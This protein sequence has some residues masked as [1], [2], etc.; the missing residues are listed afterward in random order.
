MHHKTLFSRRLLIVTGKG[1]VGKTTIA[2][3]IA[4]AARE[5]GLRTLL[6]EVGVTE[7]L[8]QIFNTWIP[9]YSVTRIEEDLHVLRLDPFLALQ[10]YIGLQMKIEWAAK[11]FMQTDVI[12]YLSQAAPGWRELITLGKIWKLEQDTDTGRLSRKAWDLIVVDA[13]ATGHGISFLRVPQVILDTL[14]YG[15]IRHH[16]Q[17]VQKLLLDPQR[18]LLNVVT[19]P[20]EMPVNEAAEIHH[21]A[22]AHLLIP[23]GFVFVNMMPQPA[24]SESQKEQASGLRKDDAAMAKLDKALDGNANALFEMAEAQEKRRALAESY[25]A[26]AK[27]RID[28]EFV[29][30]PFLYSERIDRDAL[31]Q[32]AALITKAAE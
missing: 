1:G 5:R 25:I 29:E 10:E 11:R 4:V 2:A 17:E 20:E 31:A 7:N 6:V 18:T 21:A 19:L 15:P 30:L 22:K 8:S 12:R 28:A 9:V 14:K 16:T 23:F 24:F 3:A 13:P 26:D 27:R 32:L